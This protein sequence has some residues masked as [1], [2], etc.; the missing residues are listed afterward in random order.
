M[1]LVPEGKPKGCGLTQT[2]LATG[3]EGGLPKRPPPCSRFALHKDNSDKPNTRAT[4][5]RKGGDPPSIGKATSRWYVK[6]KSG[7]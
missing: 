6:S 7:V 3:S 1:M 2:V 5:T 4:P